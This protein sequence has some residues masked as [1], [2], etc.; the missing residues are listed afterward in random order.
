PTISNY[1]KYILPVW[2]FSN[3][4]IPKHLSIIISFLGFVE[5]AIVFWVLCFQVRRNPFTVYITNLCVADAFWLLCIF[6]LYLDIITDYR[7][8]INHTYSSQMIVMLTSLFGYNTGLYLLTA[9]SVERCVSVLYPV[10]YRCHRPKH[11]SAITCSILWVLSSVMTAAEYFVCFEPTEQD[12]HFG[13]C[14]AVTIFI[15]ILNFLGFTPLI[16]MC[17]IILVIQICRNSWRPHSSKLYLI[18][19]TTVIIFLLFALPLRLILFVINSSANPIVYYIVGNSK[20]KRFRES[21]KVVLNRAFKYE[22]EPEQPNY[23]PNKDI[24]EMV[25]TVV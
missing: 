4:N 3:T 11:Q 9:I 22:T 18:I 5:N 7:L 24:I 19:V 15:F 10:W 20:K 16:I 23:N 25:N 13:K 17:N 8:S 1:T 6:L 12:P 14:V 2:L 21:L